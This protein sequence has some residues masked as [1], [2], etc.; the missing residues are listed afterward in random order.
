MGSA[1]HTASAET[2]V[3]AECQRSDGVVVLA[4]ERGAA[5]A[6]LF[7]NLDLRDCEQ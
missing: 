2:H 1:R 7:P 5:R 6:S 3:G 4:H